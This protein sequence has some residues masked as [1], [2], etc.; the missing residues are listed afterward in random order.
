M[1]HPD[2]IFCVGQESQAEEMVLP[3]VSHEVFP[4]VIAASQETTNRL[5]CFTLSDSGYTGPRGVFWRGNL[6]NTTTLPLAVPADDFTLV[7]NRL[8]TS[9][10]TYPDGIAVWE[11]AMSF[12][13]DLPL[14]FTSS[15]TF[16]F[17]NDKTRQPK[18]IRT[19]RGGIFIIAYRHDYDTGMDFDCAYTPLFPK[20]DGLYFLF[21]EITACDAGSWQL[22]K[23]DYAT[24]IFGTPVTVLTNVAPAHCR[25]A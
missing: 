24:G 5:F 23:F 4:F 20:P 22:N 17:G 1:R 11:Y 3:S 13:N 19:T 14:A 12:T 15:N 21:N 8:V 7:S 6:S 10:F 18:L 9:S 16:V 2:F 25:L